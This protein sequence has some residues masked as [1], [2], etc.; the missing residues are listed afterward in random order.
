MIKSVPLST[1]LTFHRGLTFK[2]DDLV[3]VGSEK[4][5]VCFRTKNIQ[6]ELDQTD[7]I[8]IPESFMKRCELEL[9]FGDILISS[10]NSWELVGKCVRVTELKHR[11]TLGGFISMLRPN[12]DIIDADYLFRFLRKES[13]QHQIRNMGKQTTNISNL[14]RVR[15]LE[16]CIPLPPL[17]IQKQIS[18]T[19]EK[20]DQLRKDCKQ[21]EVELNNLAE[22]VFLDMFGD[23][24]NNPKKWKFYSINQLAEIVTDGEHQTPI[25]AENGFKLLSARNVQYGYLDVVSE[26]VDYIGEE[27]FKRITKRLEIKEKDILLSCSGTIGR[28]SMNT[29]DEPFCLV[30][31][32]AVIR[33]KHGV[34][35]PEF[36]VSYLSTHYMQLKM[37]HEANSSSQANLFQNQIKKLCV[38]VPPLELQEKYCRFLEIKSK[39]LVE[40]QIFKSSLD[41]L[42]DSLLSRAFKGVLTLTDKV[43]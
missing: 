42:F 30:R 39:E 22:S 36:V 25:R 14:D 19:L 32:V 34:V 37:R 3:E 21:M 11:S 10:A 23:P 15:F 38:Y 13:T 5:I 16:I 40:L 26:K 4:S 1:V 6:D 9:R 2:P 12:L 41:D 43:A 33:L 31:S 7:L 18:A 17:N 8:A 35:I 24:L 29:L 27:E 28:V 20:A